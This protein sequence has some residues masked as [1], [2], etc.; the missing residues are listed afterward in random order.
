MLPLRI[1]LELPKKPCDV[2]RKLIKCLSV[3][4]DDDQTGVASGIED[5][6]PLW[7]LSPKQASVI[8]MEKPCDMQQRHRELFSK[9]PGE[10]GVDEAG[11]DKRKQQST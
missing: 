4:I 10:R 1:Q 7:W 3:A 8:L 6:V 5:G 9:I 11:G 2:Q